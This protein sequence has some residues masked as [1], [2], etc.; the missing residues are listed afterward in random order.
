[1]Y[2]YLI[3]LSL[4][5]TNSFQYPLFISGLYNFNTT[6]TDV[7]YA[8]MTLKTR[9]ISIP[10][11]VTILK[12]K[13]RLNGLVKEPTKLQSNIFYKDI[14]D[15]DLNLKVYKP[16]MEFKYYYTNGLNAIKDPKALIFFFLFLI[17]S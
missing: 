2:L 11:A 10:G 15:Y 16:Q 7:L 14:P 5:V 1:M 4:F 12:M 13:L 6:G 8:K 9:P 17:Y 3:I